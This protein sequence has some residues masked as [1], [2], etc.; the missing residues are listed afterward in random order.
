MIVL[1][2]YFVV[3]I[4]VN[5]LTM[6]IVLIARLI[7]SNVTVHLAPLMQNARTT[8]YATF[9]HQALRLH[10]ALLLTVCP[11]KDA[12]QALASIS[13]AMADAMKERPAQKTIAV[14]VSTNPFRQIPI[15]AEPAA[16][17]ALL[18]LSAYQEHA[19]NPLYALL[20]LIAQMITILAQHQDAQPISVIMI[21]TACHATITMRAHQVIPVLQEYASER[22]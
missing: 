16:M 14:M 17:Y 3:M 22:Q 4:F 15:T 8:A 6:K 21:Q 1:L 12:P 20:L 10:A 11:T 5:L 19:K 2:L 18:E 7:V 9:A 13:V